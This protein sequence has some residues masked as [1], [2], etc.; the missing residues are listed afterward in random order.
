MRIGVSSDWHQT[1]CSHSL[2]HNENRSQGIRLS[3]VTYSHTR[4]IGFSSE[5]HQNG[6]SHGF[7]LNENRSQQRKASN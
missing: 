1:G 7:T 4:S 6:C 2:T 5:W 3:A